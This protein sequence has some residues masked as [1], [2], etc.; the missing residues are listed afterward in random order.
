LVHG[1]EPDDLEA[2]EHAGPHLQEWLPP[3]DPPVSVVA[4][5]NVGWRN[6]A[7][8]LGSLASKAATKWPRRSWTRP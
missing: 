3:G 7:S 1:L 5:D 4:E 8:A 2:G 6:G